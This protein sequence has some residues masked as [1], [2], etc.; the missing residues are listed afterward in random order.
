MNDREKLFVRAVI[1]LKESFKNIKMTAEE[2]DAIEK[3]IIEI[4][5]V[6][7]LTTTF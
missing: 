7:N 5:Y 1:R 3:A 2:R 6:C 4:A